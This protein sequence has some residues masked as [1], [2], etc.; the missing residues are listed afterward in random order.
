MIV[1]V[2]VVVVAVAIVVVGGGGLLGECG[3]QGKAAATKRA[4][5]TGTGTSQGCKTGD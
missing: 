4:L 1:V 3:E 5:Y 2:A